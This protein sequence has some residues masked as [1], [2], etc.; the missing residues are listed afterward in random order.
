MRDEVTMATSRRPGAASSN[1]SA[2]DLADA[3]CPPPVPLVI[4]Y[5][6]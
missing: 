5:N 6:K 2:T 3:V 4:V 1:A